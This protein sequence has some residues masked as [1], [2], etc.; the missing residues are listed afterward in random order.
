MEIPQFTATCSIC[1]GSGV[2]NSSGAGA[3]WYGYSM[4]HV[5][6][7]DCIIYKQNKESRDKRAKVALAESLFGFLNLE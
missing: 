4:V 1:G 6:S 2:T 7:S 3:A 5:N